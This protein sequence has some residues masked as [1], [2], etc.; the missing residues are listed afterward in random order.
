MKQKLAALLQTARAC[1]CAACQAQVMR[2]LIR[3]LHD[4]A[5]EAP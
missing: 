5:E 4:Y 3:L 1:S 2:R